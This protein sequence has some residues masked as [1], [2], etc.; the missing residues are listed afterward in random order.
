[1]CY[2]IPY[3]KTDIPMNLHSAD[4]ENFYQKYYVNM[5]EKNRIDWSAFDY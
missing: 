4:T 2:K 1:M 5:Q 3:T